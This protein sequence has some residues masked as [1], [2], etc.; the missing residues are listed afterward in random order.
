M[1]T[2]HPFVV[3]GF[4]FRGESHGAYAT[5]CSIEV[6]TFYMFGFKKE[7]HPHFDLSLLI[8]RVALG[9]IFIV[10]GWLHVTGLEGYTQMFDEQFGF[11]APGL[12]A[13]LAAWA[14]LI[15]GITVLL[16]IF[17]RLGAGLLAIVMLVAM[18]FVKIPAGLAA[19][20]DILGL[21]QFWDKDLALFA[22][23]VVLVISNAGAYALRRYLPEGHVLRQW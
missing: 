15:G 9:L 4:V 2:A 8:L 10:F 19:G 3:G 13:L 20:N 18:I 22:I 17:T 11:V 23:A 7:S 1:M 6:T 21:T 16:G 14:E 12:L 5:V